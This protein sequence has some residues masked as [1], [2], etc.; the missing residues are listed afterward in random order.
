MQSLI[1]EFEFQGHQLK[2]PAASLFQ[3]GSAG[4]HQN[5]IKRD[6]FRKMGNMNYD[7]RVAWRLLHAKIDTFYFLPYLVEHLL[8]GN[9]HQ[10]PTKSI[11]GYTCVVF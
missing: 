6:W 3:A 9:H 1:Q 8:V 2:G 5:N 7:H 4:R 10:V 11:Y